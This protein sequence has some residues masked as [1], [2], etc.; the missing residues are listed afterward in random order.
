[1]INSRHH[2]RDTLDG[3]PLALM[4]ALTSELGRDTRRASVNL[5]S[6]G[7]APTPAP[8]SVQVHPAR[9]ACR[10]MA[11]EIP[12][13]SE[14]MRMKIAGLFAVFFYGHSRDCRRL[15]IVI[16]STSA[17]GCGLLTLTRIMALISQCHLSC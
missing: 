14:R 15:K 3:A 2:H 6:R 12:V 5:S 13:D 17:N 7:R 1:M 8:S 9:A 16:L 11:M 10:A 4:R